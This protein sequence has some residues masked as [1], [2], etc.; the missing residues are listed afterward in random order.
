MKC[1]Q[2]LFLPYSRYR[3]GTVRWR[4]LQASES[5]AQKSPNQTLMVSAPHPLPLHPD[6]MW[7]PQ[8]CLRGGEQEGRVPWENPGQAN[9]PSRTPKCYCAFSALRT[10]LAT[11]VP[12]SFQTSPKGPVN[13]TG[14]SRM[15]GVSLYQGLCTHSDVPSPS[16]PEYGAQS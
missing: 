7:S 3:I 16:K 6:D 10:S 12:Q 4:E 9:L 14:I 11:T 15:T 2:E 13:A 5:L 1:F 8:E